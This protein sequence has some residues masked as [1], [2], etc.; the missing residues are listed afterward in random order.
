MSS[1]L[2]FT[3]EASPSS[4]S[5]LYPTQCI[6][7][8]RDSFG[9]TGLSRTGTNW[10]SQRPRGLPGCPGLRTRPIGFR[11]DHGN[12][13][14]GLIRDDPPIQFLLGPTGPPPR[15]A[16]DL[17]R[18]PTSRGHLMGDEVLPKSDPQP[19]PTARKLH[20]GE[21]SMSPW[22]LGEWASCFGFHEP[23]G[24]GLVHEPLISLMG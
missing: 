23:L 18:H 16:P 15:R 2:P 3:K 20:V 13:L 17:S 21:G 10:D 1:A 12:D 5:S 22:P 24:T 9:R 11:F 4:G 14:V 7:A 6:P 19:A 8:T